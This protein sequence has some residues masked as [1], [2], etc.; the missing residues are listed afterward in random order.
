MYMTLEVT[1]NW[2]SIHFQGRILHGIEAHEHN[3]YVQI[4]RSIENKRQ[5]KVV[6][7]YSTGNCKGKNIVVQKIYSF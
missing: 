4:E 7:I 6:Q 2:K 5:K 3:I 1:V